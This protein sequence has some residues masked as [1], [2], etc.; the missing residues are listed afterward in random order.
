[1]NKKS[2]IYILLIL[3]VVGLYYYQSKETENIAIASIDL[4]KHPVY[5]S[6]RMLTTIYNPLGYL[7]Y[8]IVAFNVKHFDDSGNTEFLSPDI[9]FYN[10]EGVATWNIQANNATLTRDRLLYL[11]NKVQLD[12]LLPDTQLQRII[13]DNA[14]V[15]LNT[16]IVTSDDHVTIQGTNFTSTGTGLRGDLRD[17]TADILENV[18]THYNTPNFDTNNTAN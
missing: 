14:N 12:N 11:N 4:S 9:T 16:Q 18:K 13:T 15:N 2:L 10:Q 8:K 6:E 3:F 1:M 7:S 17:K 5:Q